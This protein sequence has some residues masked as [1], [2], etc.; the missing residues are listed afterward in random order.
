MKKNLENNNL[1]IR[2]SDHINLTFKSQMTDINN[3]TRFYYEPVVGNLSDIDLKTKI[4]DWNF[5]FPV[6]IS[7]MTG[8]SALAKTINHNLARLCSQ[9]NLGMGLGSCRIIIEDKSHLP[10]FDI[11]KIINDRPMFANLGISEIENLIHNNKIDKIIHL[12]DELQADGLI[13]HVNPLQEL[14]QPEGKV[15]SDK[16]INTIKRLLDKIEFKIIVK[17]VGQG[18]GPESLK[19]LM[20][21]PLSAIEFGA[22][23]GT[24]FSQIELFRNDKYINSQFNQ[25]IQLG[26]TPDEMV[27]FVNEI[28]SS[29]GN[30]VQCRN[31]II[32]GGIKSFLDGYYL[33]NKL[34][35]QSVYGMAS[36]FLKYAVKSY[37]DL[38]RFFL[39]HIEG[40]KVARAF[41]KVKS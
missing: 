22:Y 17:E 21:L 30:Q 20:F 28:N 4:M 37:E 3:D 1:E 35:L 9:F 8:G 14:I 39:D 10:D 15:F 11:R 16:P 5:D 19:Q 33:T 29:Y 40:L 12:L 26:H 2:K 32:S 36:Q 13:I 31:F 27:G 23:G 25:L 34:S 24:N 18:F 7:S 41:L 6:W 38:E